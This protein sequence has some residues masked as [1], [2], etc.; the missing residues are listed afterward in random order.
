[1][2]KF[3]Y[4]GLIKQFGRIENFD[5]YHYDYRSW[6]FWTYAVRVAREFGT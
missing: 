3:N 2:A 5:R 4:E 1:M 6:T